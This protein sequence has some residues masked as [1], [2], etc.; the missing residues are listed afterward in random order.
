M[1]LLSNIFYYD[2]FI[3]KPL[4][5][6]VFFNSTKWI[7]NIEVVMSKNS[8]HVIAKVNGGWKVKRADA[9]R[10]TKT[11]ATQKDAIEYGRSLSRSHATDLVIHGRDGRLSSKES[12]GNDPNPPR[13]NR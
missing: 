5:N 3:L 4:G 7:I 12:Y 9:E 1:N 8:Y 10:A 13:E 11:F 2:I 6:F